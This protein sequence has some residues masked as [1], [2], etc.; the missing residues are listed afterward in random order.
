M[1]KLYRQIGWTIFGGGASSFLYLTLRKKPVQEDSDSTLSTEFLPIYHQYLRGDYSSALFNLY[2]LSSIRPQLSQALLLLESGE[3]ETA[4]QKFDEFFAD[5]EDAVRYPYYV[6]RLSIAEVIEKRHELII[7]WPTVEKLIQPHIAEF[8]NKLRSKQHIRNLYDPF[9]EHDLRS[10][11]RHE[12]SLCEYLLSSLKNYRELINDKKIVGLDKFIY[13][14]FPYLYAEN[15][16]TNS[17]NKVIVRVWLPKNR[18]DVG[19]VSLST[20]KYYISFWPKEN[21]LFDKNKGKNIENRTLE[22]D[23]VDEGRIPDVKAIL[24]DLDIEKIHEYYEA[25]LNSDRQWSIFGSVATQDQNCCGLTRE[26][27]YVGDKDGIF[28]GLTTYATLIRS[29]LFGLISVNI[30]SFIATLTVLLSMTTVTPSDVAKMIKTAEAIQRIK[31]NKVAWNMLLEKNLELN[32]TLQDT[33]LD[34]FLNFIRFSKFAI[35][36]IVCIINRSK[37]AEPHLIWPVTDLNT[38]IVPA[39]QLVQTLRS[40]L[41]TPLLSEPE[42]QNRVKSFD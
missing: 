17:E 3:Y 16:H 35:P 27:L 5:K 31:I 25:F 26:L 10:V 11:D 29:A 28:R 8:E 9:F 39:E 6:M 1:K 36:H 22:I 12:L 33:P 7:D 32:L 41:S 18:G 38:T 37:L 19:H 14:H 30:P 4:T 40:V 2:K 21:N 24:Y 15:K 13:N 20:R 42:I 23:I 34:Q